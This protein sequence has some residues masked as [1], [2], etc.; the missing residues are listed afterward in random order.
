MSELC[1]SEKAVAEAV[2]SLRFESWVIP[3]TTT[4]VVA[5]VLPDGWVVATGTSGCIDSANFDFDIGV[6][7]ATEA[8]KAA[9]TNKLWE[10]LGWELKQKLICA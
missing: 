1:V 3:E 6:E 7:F 5:A 8:A 10:L 2:D 9:A 4:T